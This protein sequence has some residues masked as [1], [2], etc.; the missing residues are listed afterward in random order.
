[1]NKIF[2]QWQNKEISDIE[3]IRA[4]NE[5]N[6]EL[7]TELLKSISELDKTGFAS[8]KAETLIM[9]ITGWPY[10]KLN[11][12]LTKMSNGMSIEEVLQHE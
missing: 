3:C 4:L 10:I 2:P 11:D 6:K 9:Q 12:V 7:L 1:M 8:I 5:Q